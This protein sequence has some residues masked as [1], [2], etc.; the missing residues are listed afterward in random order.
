[1]PWPLKRIELAPF[2]A[3]GLVEIEFEDF[4]DTEKPASRRFRVTY[5]APEKIRKFRI[6]NP[7]K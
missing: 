2:S 5:Q 6:P 1:M 4:L 7:L 3:C